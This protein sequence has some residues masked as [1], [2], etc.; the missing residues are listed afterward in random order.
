MQHTEKRL[1]T[2]P[3]GF[4]QRGPGTGQQI[5]APALEELP[6]GLDRPVR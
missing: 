4:G 2:L 6:L 5:V 3:L 1:T